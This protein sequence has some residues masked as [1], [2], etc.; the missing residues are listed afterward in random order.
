MKTEKSGD[1]A[2]LKFLCELD[3]SSALHVQNAMKKLLQDDTR[4]FVIDLHDVTF[5]DSHGVGLFAMLLRHAHTKNGFLAF[6][7]AEGQ[8]KS[9]LKMVGF[10][11]MVKY[12]DTVEDAI[13][14]S[15]VM[16][17]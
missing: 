11:E 16:T 14:I 2:I 12:Y 10:D 6:C 1:I 13:N 17:K 5:L 7:G 4:S 15:Q 3:A 9:V 8:P